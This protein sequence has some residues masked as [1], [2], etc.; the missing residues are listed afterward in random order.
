[1]AALSLI[2]VAA[3]QTADEL[4]LGLHHRAPDASGSARKSAS[5]QDQINLSLRFKP[6]M[7]LSLDLH[8]RAPD[9]EIRQASRARGP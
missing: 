5:P 7:S 9:A 1:V 3:L 2:I 4:S 6:L 8:H